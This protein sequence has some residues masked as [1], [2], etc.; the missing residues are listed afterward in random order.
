MKLYY[1]VVAPNPTKVRLYLAEK[2]AAGNPI[3]VEE[4]LVNL[5]EGE[6][7]TPE[8]LARHPFGQLPVLELD[9]GRF[10]N[11]SLPIIEYLEELHPEAPMIGE[12]AT[13]RAR[14]RSLERAAEQRVLIMLAR[15]IHTTQSPLGRPANPP[16]AA[17]FMEQLP[18]GLEFFDG[19]LGDGR[20]FLA[21]ER[22]TIAD[23]TL[24][25]AFQ[26]GRM[27]EYEIDAQYAHLKRWD[28]AFRAR[29]SAQEIFVLK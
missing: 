18:E 26:F 4:I 3:E 1:F 7:K 29:P 8:H 20:P 22:P 16:V 6:Q 24:A 10:I 27:V 19:L 23:C 14:V 2:A 9:D 17:Y 15:Y 25:A 13:E 12:D 5:R 11:E 21:G 28:A